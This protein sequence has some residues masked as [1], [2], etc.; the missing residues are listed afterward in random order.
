MTV[1]LDVAV[2]AADDEDDRVLLERIRELAR[3]CRLAM[4]EAARAELAGLA[5]DLDDHR[6]AVDEVELVLLVVVVLEALVAGRVDDRVHAEGGDAE[7][8]ADLAEAVAVAELV[9]GGEAWA[10]AEQAGDV[11]ASGRRPRSS[12]SCFRSAA[13]KFEP[14]SSLTSARCVALASSNFAAPAGVSEAY[15]TRASLE[16]GFFSTQPERSSP[17]RR[18]VIP[19]AV[20]RTDRARSTLRSACSGAK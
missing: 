12:P 19:E 4:E 5:L 9:E 7:G 18:R 20:S 6:P 3:R 13:E 1:A 16:Q 15:E 17:S 14:K 11:S 8:A 10:H 2:L